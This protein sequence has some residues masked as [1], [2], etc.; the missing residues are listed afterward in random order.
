VNA[1][2]V[3]CI[4][5]AFLCLALGIGLGLWFALDRASGAVW[6]PLHAALNLWG[7]ATLLIYGMSYHMLPR[8]TGRPLRWPRLAEAQSWLAILAVALVGLGWLATRFE[9]SAGRW[10]LLGGGTLQ[11]MAALLYALQIGDLLVGPQ[12]EK[13]ATPARFQSVGHPTK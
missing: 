9:L 8:F 11:F 3:R 6:R 2:T 7:W 13:R 1:L 4:R 5:A 12:R 10:L